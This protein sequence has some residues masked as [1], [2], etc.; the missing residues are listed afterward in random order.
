MLY[1]AWGDGVLTP[2]ELEAVRE[3]AQSLFAWIDP[4]ARDALLAWLRPE[5]PPTARQL[6]ALRA[7]VRTAATRCPES[8]RR[9]LAALGMGI[10]RLD[11]GLGGPWEGA[12]ATA[13]LEQLEA[14]LGVVGGEATRSLL[15]APAPVPQPAPA[16]A[17]LFD[18]STLTRFLRL[19]AGDLRE[20]ILGLLSDPRLRIR[21]RP[22]VP[23]YRE[24]VLDAVGVLAAG[25]YGALGFPRSAGGRGDPVAAIAVFE[26]L[27]FGDLSVMTKFGVQFGLFGGSVLHLG[28]EAH[29]RLLP[30][31]GSLALPGCF[32]MTE[33]DHGSNVRGIRTTAV[34]DPDTDEIVIDTPD[35]GA[36]K[37]WIGNAAVHGRMAAV[38]V[39]LEVEGHGHGVH[40]VLVPIRGEAGQP[41]PGVRIEDC[42]EKVG[43]NG[44]DNG[45]LE[46]R[47]VR[48]PRANLLDRY[49]SINDRGEYES[50]IPS[51]GRRFFTM[52]GA[53]VAGRISIAAASVSVAKTA[54]TTAIRYSEGRRQFGPAGAPEVPVLDY[55]VHQRS[56]L[57]RLARTYGLHFAVRDLV[58]RYG[59]AGSDP[60]PEIEALA[61]GLK[62]AASRH[63][64]DTVQA[65][66]EACG[67]VGYLA[68]NRFGELRSDADIFTTFEGAN[69]V[70]LQL[71]ARAL[72]GRYRDQM[73]DLKLWDLVRHLA[74]RGQTRVSEMNP[75]VTRN[76]DE[77]HLRDPEFVAAALA[78]R[79]DRL[80]AS[81]ARRLRSRIEDGM[82]SFDAM[83][84]CQDHLVS[85]AT[86][87]VDRVV[88]E[89][90]LEGVA[91]APTP[92][93]SELLRTL[94]ELHGLSRLERDRS[95]YLEAG[96]LE[97][98]KSR[99]IRSLVNRLCGEVREQAVFLVDAFGIPDAV[100]EAPAATP[101]PTRS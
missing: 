44:V 1:V 3:R 20:E 88:H 82:D 14:L 49:A 55:L 7:R 25:G 77:E 10:A 22:P 65:C 74:D 101:G 42:G 28:T 83:N 85:L 93:L 89:R 64:L 21:P 15:G 6:E 47:S 62:A 5:R 30:D 50:G 84:A 51:Q 59:E 45:R 31:I 52:L 17:D 96:Y 58:R 75:I 98:P 91:R 16:V 9:S 80:L 23:Q 79:E 18:V 19:P 97:A 86:A 38:F 78:Y 60:D 4:E 27:A 71:V 43:L 2:E 40:V 39:Q 48:V 63:A 34:Y 53:L 29:H 87:H 66:R 68:A 13:A 72:L 32:A 76:T 56:L 35:P 61:A 94:S 33:V 100:L 26:T 12:Q 70:L 92:G 36:R 90:F 67:G 8:V 69:P 46:F 54:L 11:P 57:P 24:A 99:A 41:L 73:G 95:W 37:D 81:V